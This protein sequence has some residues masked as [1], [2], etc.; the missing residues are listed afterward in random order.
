[1]IA[2]SLTD[3]QRGTWEKLSGSLPGGSAAAPS[4]TPAA[5]PG[6]GGS[7]PPGPGGV[8]GQ[9]AGGV[10][11][12]DATEDGMYQLNFVLTPWKNVIEYFAK[13]GGY[14][15]TTDKWPNGTFTYTDPKT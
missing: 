14:A 9:R 2:R 7:A 5:P 11:E 6:P 3:T 15:F 1:M 8:N 4:S 13:K 12:L 10:A